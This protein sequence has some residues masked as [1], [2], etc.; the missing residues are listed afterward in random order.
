MKFK[1]EICED[2]D[3]EVVVRC[4]KITKEIEALQLA[5]KNTINNQAHDLV[6]YKDGAEFYLPLESILFFETGRSSVNAHTKDDEFQVKYKLY[7]LENMLP[8]YFMRVSKSTIINI[9]QIYSINYNIASSSRVDF[10]NTYKKI[11]VSRMYYKPLKEKM[12]GRYQ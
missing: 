8:G 5:I 3:E 2:G 9:N 4:K 6:L 11:F 1:T 12:K 10:Y 7:E